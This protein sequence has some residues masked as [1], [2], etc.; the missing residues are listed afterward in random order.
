MFDKSTIYSFLKRMR[1]RKKI[2]KR[3]GNILLDNQ[4]FGTDIFVNS[5]NELCI[6]HLDG[7]LNFKAFIIKLILRFFKI[8]IEKKVAN[9]L[10]TSVYLRHWKPDEYELGDLQ[11][12]I[13]DGNSFETLINQVIYLFLLNLK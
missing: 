12:V 4:V 8:E 3:P 11:E 2:L 10:Q 5:T 9:K 6:E 1:L 13:L 7:K